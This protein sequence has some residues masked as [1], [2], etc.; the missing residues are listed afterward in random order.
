MTAEVAHLPV[1]VQERRGRGTHRVGERVGRGVDRAEQ[2]GTA[3]ARVRASRGH[4]CIA[5]RTGSGGS[6]TAASAA[7]L[8]GAKNRSRSSSVVSP[9]SSDQPQ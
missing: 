6:A 5:T 9:M 4:P 3:R 2:L 1:A 7:M 8:S